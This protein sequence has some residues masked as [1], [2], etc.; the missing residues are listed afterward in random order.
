MGRIGV[1]GLNVGAGCNATLRAS[2][3]LVGLGSEVTAFEF[4]NRSL[5][6]LRERTGLKPAPTENLWN[7]RGVGGWEEGLVHSLITFGLLRGAGYLARDQNLVFQ[8]AFQS[9][10][11]VAGQNIVDGITEERGDLKIAPPL[12]EQFL[13]A[14]AIN[15]QMGAGTGLMHSMAPGIHALERGLDL[16]LRNVGATHA[17]PLQT[18]RP[19]VTLGAHSASPSPQEGVKKIFFMS[20]LKNAGSGGQEKD[21]AKLYRPLFPEESQFNF[22]EEIIQKALQTPLEDPLLK[23]RLLESYAHASNK[24]SLEQFYTVFAV[25]DLF[26]HDAIGSSAGSFE[27]TLLQTLLTRILSE[28]A[29][30]LRQKRMQS[31]FQ[32]MEEGGLSRQRMKDFF[33]EWGYDQDFRSQVFPRT[34]FGFWETHRSGFTEDLKRYRFIDKLQIFNFVYSL[35][36]HSPDQARRLF[37]LFGEARKNQAYPPE[38][39]DQALAYA[40]RHPMGKLILRRLLQILAV[41]DAPV[42]LKELTGD[43]DE[44]NTLLWITEMDS[45]GK[46]LESI[47]QAINGTRHNAYFDDIRM[48]RKSVKITLEA[49]PFILGNKEE[50]DMSRKRLFQALNDFLVSGKKLDATQLIRLLEVNGTTELVRFHR[51]WGE[52][53]FDFEVISGPL[54]DYLLK[55]YDLIPDC[56]E[57]IYLPKIDKQ[58]A[59]YLKEKSPPPVQKT[60]RQEYQIFLNRLR[61]RDQILIRDMPPGIPRTEGEKEKAL[62][63]LRFR[64]WGLLHEWGHFLHH[65]GNDEAIREGEEPLSLANISR[66]RRLMTEVWAFLQEQPW[67]VKNIDIDPWIFG[68]RLG[69][70]FLLYFR[71]LNDQSYFGKTNE[72]L[73]NQLFPKSSRSENET[74]F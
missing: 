12:A 39:I 4:V 69:E 49:A 65:S 51:Q 71:H 16:S 21:L 26:G 60:L 14:E 53:K 43:P 58:Q 56:E 25:K 73:M 64:L 35:A 33:K 66:E 67:R 62:H 36:E 19:Y 74:K 72:K 57:S 2:S 45:K 41:E 27:N 42:K 48:A 32:V 38:A 24:G 70:N 6:S 10:A 20:S 22:T 17:S 31:V 50:R 63:H 61:E 40:R 15:L 55:T 68:E 37:H 23:E 1:M 44:K 59:H 46:G 47:A 29:P 5:I 13:Q 3:I 11:M 9:S 34:S 30:P 18:D 54:F 28:K 52:K 8:H 7:W